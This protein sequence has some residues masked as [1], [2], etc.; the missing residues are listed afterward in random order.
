MFTWYLV[1]PRHFFGAPKGLV[2]DVHDVREPRDLADALKAIL[3]G[4]ALLRLVEGQPLEAVPCG[5]AKRLWIQWLGPVANGLPIH[6][7]HVF[8]E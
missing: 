2:H 6:Q 8:I 7:V 5:N 1:P 4:L 3:G